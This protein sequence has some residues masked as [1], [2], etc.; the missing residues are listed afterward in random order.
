LVK[1]IRKG[2]GRKAVIAYTDRRP[3]DP[4]RLVASS[5]KIDEELG[6]RWSIRWNKSLKA[7]GDGIR[8]KEDDVETAP[9][10]GGC[11]ILSSREGLRFST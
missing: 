11:F 2:N 4:A 9:S 6:G 7:Q 10:R 3:G 8:E 1:E 5:Q